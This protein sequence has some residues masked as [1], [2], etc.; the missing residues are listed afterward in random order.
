VAVEDD[1]DGG[2]TQ[3]RA[4]AKLITISRHFQVHSAEKVGEGHDGTMSSVASYPVL[5]L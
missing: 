1:D 4:A 2:A 5:D 3:L